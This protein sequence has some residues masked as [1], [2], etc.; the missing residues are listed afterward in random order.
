MEV[1]D[2]LT[3]KVKTHPKVSAQVGFGSYSTQMV[4]PIQAN[5]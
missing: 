4:T 5:C 3:I 1:K 2:A